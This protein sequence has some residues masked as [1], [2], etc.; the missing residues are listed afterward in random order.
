VAVEVGADAT[1]LDLKKQI[2]EAID[3]EEKTSQITDY[4]WI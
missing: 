4:A 1:V 2:G 3:A